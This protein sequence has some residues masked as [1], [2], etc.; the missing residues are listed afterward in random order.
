M[1]KITVYT[2][3]GKFVKIGENKKNGSL[4]SY[5]LVKDINRASY[6]TKLS[7]AKS[8]LTAI[9]A[10]YPTAELKEVELVLKVK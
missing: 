2:V 9:K 10:K 6:F 8:W 4:F 5:R 3:N 1:E 7:S